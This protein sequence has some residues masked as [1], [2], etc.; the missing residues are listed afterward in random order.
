MN[1]MNA[2]MKFISP[3]R[4]WS[5]PCA[6]QI[7]ASRQLGQPADLILLGAIQGSAG[8]DALSALAAGDLP[9]VATVI[10]D[11][12]LVVYPRSEQ[13]PPP[14]RLAHLERGQT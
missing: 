9:G 4:S 6:P 2:V 12:Q 5:T 8:S 10:V 11:G 1:D 13:T 3:L 7:A 14:T